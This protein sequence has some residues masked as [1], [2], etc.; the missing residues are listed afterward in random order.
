MVS[1][2]EDVSAGAYCGLLE[3]IGL[4]VLN[5]KPA[6]VSS[7]E[8][9]GSGRVH[10]Q[11]AEVERVAIGYLDSYLSQNGTASND[12]GLIA[13]VLRTLFRCAVRVTRAV[14][15]SNFETDDVVS[16][17]A[18]TD[19][20]LL[21]SVALLKRYKVHWD[22]LIVDTL[23][24]ECLRMGDLAGVYFVVRQMRKRGISARTSTL[25]CFLRRYAENG[26]AESAFALVNKTM[27]ISPYAIPSQTSFG[28]LLAACSRSAKGR[29][30]AQSFLDGFLR[31]QMTKLDWERLLDYTVQV[32]GA[33]TEVLRAMARTGF[34]ADDSTVLLLL[35]AFHRGDRPGDALSLFD[36]QT[37]ARNVVGRALPE[38]VQLIVPPPSRRSVLCL[39]ELLREAGRADN[40]TSNTSSRSCQSLSYHSPYLLHRRPR[41]CLQRSVQLCFFG[42]WGAFP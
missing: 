22:M 12:C 24:E 40:A 37:D 15:D 32:G 8:R 20:A 25:D 4:Y 27:A 1:V 11:V 31:G 5:S 21:S 6:A 41:A 33:W 28:L 19:V 3:G 10:L 14:M 17:A 36:M 42:A 26:D 16:N 29:W 34:A 9:R 13:T 7:L 35:N 30:L 18:R 39:L 38:C 23:L 2:G